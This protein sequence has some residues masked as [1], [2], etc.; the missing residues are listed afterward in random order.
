M[1]RMS[2]PEQLQDGLPDHVVR[3][4]ALWGQLS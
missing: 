3:N 4:R 2:E 1:R